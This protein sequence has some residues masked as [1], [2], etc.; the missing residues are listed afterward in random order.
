MTDS[1]QSIVKSTTAA[2]SSISDHEIIYL[3]T[4]IRVR[5]PNPHR[6]VFRN[7]RRVDQVQL[8][9]DFQARDHQPILECADV[10]MK[11]EMVTTEMQYLL[12]RHAPQRTIFVR[13]QR[14]PWISNEIIQAV[15]LRDLAY[16]L[17]ARNPNRARGDRNW[18]DYCVQR[19][20]AATLV[21]TAKR[22]Y[23]NKNF[24]PELPA[25]KLWSNLRRDGIHNSSKQSENDAVFDANLLNEFFCRRP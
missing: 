4:D 24:A 5:K 10:N 1:P 12:E 6:V 22:R 23:A 11:A 25:K 21:A 19:D 2:G 7:M 8:Q 9:A 16:K 17:Y 3:I 20:R 18:Q 14:T 13:D 15:A